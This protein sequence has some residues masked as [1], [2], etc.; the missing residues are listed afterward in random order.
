P[1]E[2]KGA[3]RA[4]GWPEDAEFLVPDGV[5]DTFR[6]GIGK[7]GAELHAQWQGF[8]QAAREADA[9]HAEDLDAFLQGRL[10]DGWDRDIPVFEA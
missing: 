10:P 9:G 1:D 4:Y 5:L 8:F 7:R 6:D 3:K 2:V